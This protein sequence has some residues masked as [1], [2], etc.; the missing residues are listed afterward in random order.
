MYNPNGTCVTGMWVNNLLEWKAEIYQRNGIWS[1]CHYTNGKKEGLEKF[2][3]HLE[4]PIVRR[5]TVYS[6]G[7]KHGPEWDFFEDGVTVKQTQEF[8]YGKSVGEI[9]KYNKYGEKVGF[10]AY[11]F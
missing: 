8:H 1:K 2:Y 9:Q 7:T 4:N 3:Y 5:I 11:I 10:E 6:K